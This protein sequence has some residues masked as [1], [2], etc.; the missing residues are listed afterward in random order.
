MERLF[1]FEFLMNPPNAS[2]GGRARCHCRLALVLT[3]LLCTFV[4]G[5][6]GPASAVTLFQ[7]SQAVSDYPRVEVYLDVADGQGN[8]LPTPELGGLN[9]TADGR[10]L[11]VG[12]VRPFATTGQGVGYVFLVDISRSLGESELAGMRKAIS[13]WVDSCGDQDRF[14]LVSFG[15]EVCVLQDFT[16][17]KDGFLDRVA[18]LHPTDMLTSLH[19]ALMEAQRLGSRQDP[20]LPARRVVIVL[21]D[22]KNESLYGETAREVL[23]DLREASAPIFALGY[24]HPPF[25]GKKEHLQQLAR[26]ARASG[27]TYF[28]PGD[29][30]LEV[31]FDR[32]RSRIDNTW[33]VDLDVADISPQGQNLHVEIGYSQGEGLLTDAF[34]VRLIPPALALSSTGGVS[35]EKG[36]DPVTFPS[37]KM[38]D[39]TEV[40]PASAVEEDSRQEE[41]SMTGQNQDGEQP[42]AGEEEQQQ[43]VGEEKDGFSPVILIGGALLVGLF[44]L[45]GLARKA[46]S[47]KGDAP[48]Q[49]VPV[50]EQESL[51]ASVPSGIPLR[52]EV[53]RGRRV[54]RSFRLFLS[55]SRTLG[56]SEDNDI[57]IVDDRTISGRHCEL[58]LD[59][60]GLAVRDLGSTN[61]TF[62]NNLQIGELTPLKDG[63]MLRIGQTTIRFVFE[64]DHTPGGGE[65]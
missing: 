8:S 51:A 63:D 24:Y 56:R 30:G 11:T 52:L 65:L 16:S 36:T 22:G 18:E 1:P 60:N 31:V 32:L 10:K 13:S 3:L 45:W 62:V 55:G 25:E 37:G 9:A 48:V 2:G 12:S 54:A 20:G 34:D 53:F 28:R 46:G 29:D 40:L 47:R 50:P 19:G 43:T 57:S 42:R 7:A 26:F 35:P 14:A 27:G 5:G 61:G 39:S 58:V 38:P 44:L 64:E 17:E 4:L 33:V 6:T 23:H 15:S 21:S 41:G 59:G 49:E